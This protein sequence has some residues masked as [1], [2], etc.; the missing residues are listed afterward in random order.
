[1]QDNMKPNPGCT[2]LVL[3]SGLFPWGAKIPPMKFSTHT[4][5]LSVSQFRL[6]I[7]ECLKLGS[8]NIKV[9]FKSQSIYIQTANFNRSRMCSYNL[10][11]EPLRSRVSA[12][13]DKA[14]KDIFCQSKFSILGCKRFNS[15]HISDYPSYIFNENNS[16]T[17][18]DIPGLCMHLVL[19]AVMQSLTHNELSHHSLVDHDFESLSLSGRT[20]KLY[21]VNLLHAAQM[22]GWYLHG[23]VANSLKGAIH[24]NAYGQELNAKLHSNAIKY[25]HHPKQQITFEFSCHT[26]RTLDVLLTFKDVTAHDVVCYLNAA[27]NKDLSKAW[28]QG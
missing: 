10:V 28:T 21:L 26:F 12:G 25:H 7:L 11:F 3:Y 18:V 17:T 5:A 13:N 23:G 15:W 9:L 8:S 27:S 14:I 6:V 2:S 19:A 16:L 24:P 20:R 4:T 1:M 22:S